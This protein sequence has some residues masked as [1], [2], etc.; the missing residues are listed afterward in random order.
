[1]V[2][3]C[4]EDGIGHEAHSEFRKEQENMR[5]TKDR[6]QAVETKRAVAPMPCFTKIVKGKG[7]GKG[8]DKDILSPWVLNYLSYHPG[9]FTN[10]PHNVNTDAVGNDGASTLCAAGL[11]LA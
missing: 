10:K 9:R 4:R 6:R 3:G 1:V 8:K 2:V 11:R 7:K 5:P